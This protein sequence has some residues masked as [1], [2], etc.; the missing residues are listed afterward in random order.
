MNQLAK[1]LLE[2]EENDQNYEIREKL[3]Y[4]AL[5]LAKDLGLSAGIR[6]DPDSPDWPVVTIMLP[7][8]QISWHNPK[9]EIE[10]DGHSTEEKYARIHNFM[11]NR[12]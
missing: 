1:V 6:V 11:D 2:I 8:G 9:S 3:V 12:G 10:Y 4:K 7:T 5:Y